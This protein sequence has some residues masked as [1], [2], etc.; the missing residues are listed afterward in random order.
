MTEW[1]LEP[2]SFNG[3]IGAEGQAVGVKFTAGLDK[4]GA[5]VIQFERFPLDE[6][7]SFISRH[8]HVGGTKFP[9]F[10]LRGSSS[11]GTLFEC[12]NLIFTS[13]KSETNFSVDERTT[14][15]PQA[16][17]SQARFTMKAEPVAAPM[18]KWHL[19]GFE[20]FRPLRASS[21]LG[22]VE[23]AGLAEARGVD[24]ITGALVVRAENAPSDI[25]EW[26][27]K[28]DDHCID[29]R[30]IMSFALST[31]FGG[32]IREF[33]HGDELIIDVFLDSG[34]GDQSF[35]VF[36]SL[37]L[38]A[39]F[40]CAVR[41]HFEPPIDVKNLVF[42]IKWF[43]M[44]ASYR[45]GALITAMT[46]LENLIDSNLSED[47]TYILDD[48]KFQ[49]L[50]K[51]LSGEIK[52]QAA[53]WTADRAEQKAYI[54]EMCPKLSE[55]RRRSL[56]GKISLLAERWGVSLDGI[57]NGAIQE[58]K[59]ARDQVVHR[60]HYQSKKGSVRDLHDHVLTI[61]EVVVRFILAAVGFEGNYQSYLDGQNFVVM[62]RNKPETKSAT[63]S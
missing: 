53:V 25:V 9:K 62:R 16:G 19:K 6:R 63:E 13:L 32:P 36:S 11:D 1:M 48:D 40:E 41:W 56:I 47:D 22:V 45:E 4:A 30:H 28:V 31:L 18:V 3:T 55:L 17:Y 2:N 10:V 52:R 46:V 34:G 20:S 43:C 26:R 33:R 50:R 49:I 60:G 59:S 24:G 27:A 61:R 37:S 12:D 15:A 54:A 51:A 39:I 57:P 35:P 29:V 42:A 21:P 58:A 44:K 5:L 7:S 14:I 23:M 8:S 38:E